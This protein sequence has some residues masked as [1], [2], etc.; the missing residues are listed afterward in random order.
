MRVMEL[1]QG[2]SPQDQDFWPNLAGFPIS[3]SDSLRAGVARANAD[4][5]HLRQLNAMS[6]D[7]LQRRINRSG[8][9]LAS[10]PPG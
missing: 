6:D 8:F 4:C 10:K 3:S 1:L 5:G 2:K 9:K 7:V